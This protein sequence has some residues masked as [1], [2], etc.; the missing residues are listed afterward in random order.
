LYQVTAACIQPL[1]PP[2]THTLLH[3]HRRHAGLGRAGGSAAQPQ[4]RQVLAAGSGEQS[5]DCPTGEGGGVLGVGVA[6]VVVVVV[7]VASVWGK[8]GGCE[9]G[10]R[11]G[12]GAAPLPPSTLLSTCQARTLHKH[13]A[14]STAPEDAGGRGH[15]AQQPL[16]LILKTPSRPPSLPPFSCPWPLL[17]L[18]LLLLRRRRRWRAGDGRAKE[19]V[20]AA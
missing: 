16:V 11:W 10:K 9:V 6:A 14:P 13:Q 17:L 4:S 2:P 8:G 3:T 18:F 7:G 1:C 5:A 19:E 12:E 15:K 20:I